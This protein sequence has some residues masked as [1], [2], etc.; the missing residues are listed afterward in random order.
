MCFNFVC[1]YIFLGGIMNIIS[2]SSAKGTNFGLMTSSAY[3]KIMD[4]KGK[5]FDDS[6]VDYPL[7][8]QSDEDF[9]FH[10]NDK[11]ERFEL[12]SVDYNASFVITDSRIKMPK[13]EFLK[14]IIEKMDGIRNISQLLTKRDKKLEVKDVTGC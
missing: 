7:K 8:I 14:Y 12:Y 9:I 2:V 10:H 5:N 3:K 13:V 1:K 4:M 11:K 6:D